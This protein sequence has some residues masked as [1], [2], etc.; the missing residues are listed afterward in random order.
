MAIDEH[1]R[2]CPDC[3]VPLDEEANCLH[4]RLLCP[5]CWDAA[6]AETYRKEMAAAS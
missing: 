3:D 6:Y 5:D 2:L 4:G 1:E